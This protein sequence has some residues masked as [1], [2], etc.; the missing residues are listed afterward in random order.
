MSRLDAAIG[1]LN[2][3]FGDF[4]ARERN[5]LALPLTFRHRGRRL[6]LDRESLKAA[7]PRAGGALAV[8]LHG[9]CC[10]EQSWAMYGDE[11]WHD[12]VGRGYG[13][14][15]EATLGL[16][17]L[18]VRYNT[19]RHISES[20][21]DFARA[22][23]Q[24]VA[25]WPAKVERLVLIGHS[26]GGLVA[27]SASHH[28]LERG[29]AWTEKVTH[30]V[31]LGSPHQGAP[32][33]RFGNVATVLLGAFDITRPLATAINARSSGIKDLRYGSLRHEDWRDAHPDEFLKDR[34]AAPSVLPNARY[35]FVGATLGDDPHDLAGRLLGDGLVPTPSAAGRHKDDSRR[36]PF[37]DGDGHLLTGLH[38]LQLLNHPEIYAQL[39]RWLR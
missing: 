18:Y 33:E 6:A 9:L 31:C 23:E 34:R 10:D 16:T 25:Q 13:E 4:L 32:L 26:M 22:L 7:Y 39:V 17:P 21:E 36:A 37:A 30:I 12:G 5:P 8:Y 24:L 2:G 19:G 3:V 11:H 29:H 38:H 27:R 15:L 14:R 28:A 20:G 35:H 1:A